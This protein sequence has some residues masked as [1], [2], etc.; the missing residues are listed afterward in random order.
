MDIWANLKLMTLCYI[1][2]QVLIFVSS[3]VKMEI[4]N[5]QVRRKF[6]HAMIGNLTLI[7][8][9][10]SESIFPFLVASPFIIVTFIVSPFSPWPNLSERLN[11]L[12]RITAEGNRVGLI[13]Y[14]ISY[15]MLT[16]LYGSRPS[17]VA[18]GI[19]PMAYGDG[20]AAL[21]GSKYGRHTPRFLH[22]KSLEGCLGMFFGSII[23]LLCG[24]YYFSIIYKF[25]FFSQF[26]TI[27]I[28]S[29]VVT[30]VEACSPSGTDNLTVP[31]LGSFVF[32]LF[33]GG[34]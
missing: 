8:P 29:S 9:F 27:F 19:F 16:L 17:V 24:M 13:L 21:V 31:I 4:G 10:F 20:I 1:Y 26:I 15:S 25:N 34:V 5:S 11:G 23:S 22:N 28:V 7:M 18:A 14:A 12:T 33:G 6:L 30:L 32:V 2:I 3:T